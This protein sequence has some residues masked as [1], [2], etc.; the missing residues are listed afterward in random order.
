MQRQ[1]PPLDERIHSVVMRGFGLRTR[2]FSHESVERV[3]AALNLARAP[4]PPIIGEVLWMSAPIAFTLPGRYAYI[5]RSLIEYC[6]SDAAVAFP[7]AHEMAH[8]DLGHIKRTDRMFAAQGLAHTPERFAIL[9]VELL[10]RRLYSRDHE[11]WADAYAIGLC[12]RAG[13]DPQ[14]C[15]QCFDVFTRYALDRHDLDGVYGTDEEI[16]LD[17]GQATGSVDRAYVEFRLW[18]ARHRRSHPSI[19]E[20]RQTLLKQIA[21]MRSVRK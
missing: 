6:A 16:E 13:F 21:A 20:R 15:L 14:Q 4:L 19:H 17:P 3:A 11:F 12:R 1:K 5:S 2:D 18:C 10:S 8:H 7:L 9:L